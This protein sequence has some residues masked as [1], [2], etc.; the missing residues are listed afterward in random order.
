MV[1]AWLDKPCGCCREQN[2]DRR[3]R[4]LKKGVESLFM[5]VFLTGPQTRDKSYY[6]IQRPEQNDQDKESH[7][8]VSN[9]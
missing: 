2:H 3:D 9:G 5:A 7:H 1:P 8:I 6:E 4:I